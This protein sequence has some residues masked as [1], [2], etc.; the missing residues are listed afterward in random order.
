MVLCNVSLWAIISG[1]DITRGYFG[2]DISAIPASVT[3]DGVSLKLTAYNDDSGKS[4]TTPV[5]YELRSAGMFSSGTCTW[6]NAPALGTLLSELDVAPGNLVVRK[7]YN[8]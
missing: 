8:V 3:I 7:S 6:N 5:T 4:G 1:T 2:F